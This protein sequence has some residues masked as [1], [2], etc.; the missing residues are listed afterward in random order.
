MRKPKPV[1][2]AS[3]LDRLLGCNGSRRLLEKVEV[4]AEDV[5]GIPPGDEMTWRGNWGHYDSATRLVRE[6]G[7][8]GHPEKPILPPGWKPSIWDERT[9]DWFVTN[10]LLLTPDGHQIHV[11]KRIT[12]EFDRFILSGQIDVFT[13]DQE[14]EDFTIDD[15][16]TG[17]NPVSHAEE[18]WQLC[19]YAVLLKHMFPTLKRGKIR[20]LQKAVDDQIT[21]ADVYP[22]DGLAAFLEKQI[23]EAL[24][25]EYLLNSGYKQCRL[26][27]GIYQ[28]EAL[29]EEIKAMQ[30]LLTPEKLEALLEIPDLNELAEICARGRAIAGPIDKLL[31]RLKAR[32]EGSKPVVLKDGTVV[33]ITEENGKR[34]ITHPNI[35]FLLAQD[36][37]GEEAAWETLSMSIGALEDK[38]VASGMQRGSKKPEI[39]TAQSWIKTN[40]SHLITRSKHK[41]LSFK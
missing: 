35:G 2:R 3:S 22:I 36:K 30:I 11:E 15:N 4:V 34:T 26:C 5:F 23:N 27:E 9:S 38:L 32:L 16:K 14:Y 28:C 8:F 1:I 7:A 17:P 10:V 13:I 31:K 18:N 37:L 19:A 12:M 25:H 39:E 20:I 6:H 24:D 41:E 40:F 21:E 33:T 29:H